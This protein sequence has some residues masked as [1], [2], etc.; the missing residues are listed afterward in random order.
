MTKTFNFILILIYFTS[1]KPAIEACK[2]NK[3]TFENKTYRSTF[4]IDSN[5]IDITNSYAKEN[6]YKC[7]DSVY[8]TLEPNGTLII[9][10]DR[11]TDKP[12][13]PNPS[14]GTWSIFSLDNNN[15]F[16]WIEDSLAVQV[17]SFSC[18]SFVFKNQVY[19]EKSYKLTFTQTFTV[20]N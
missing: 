7:L 18:N 19:S 17:N 6:G 5:N 10:Y 11:C 16:Y 8:I 3:S 9:N 20:V 13:L 1:C 12:D 15:Y 4:R 2:F 14:Y